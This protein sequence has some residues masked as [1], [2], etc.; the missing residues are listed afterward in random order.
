M[1]TPSQAR[2]MALWALFVALL[3]LCGWQEVRVSRAQR[4]LAQEQAAHQ[5]TKAEEA[6][7]LRKAQTDARQTESGLRAEL[8]A[9]QARATQEMENAKAR[10]DALVESVRAGNRRL[11]VAAR[12]PAGPAAGGGATPAGGGGPAAP[13]AELAP[14]AAERI[15]AIGRDGDR[16]TR[17]RNLC[18]EAYEEARGRLNALN[19]RFSDAAGQ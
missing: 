6:E 18:V 13:R 2:V 14:E 8:E 16:N 5:K 1:L 7:K 9:K 11:S 3:A 15:L 19:K 10:E 4:D 12:C 17:E